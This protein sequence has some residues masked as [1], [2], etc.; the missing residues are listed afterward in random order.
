MYCL[1]RCLIKLTALCVKMKIIYMPTKIQ[2]AAL[3]KSQT[4]ACK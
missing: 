3:I 4:L 1:V 2:V